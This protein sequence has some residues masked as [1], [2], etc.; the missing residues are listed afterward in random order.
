MGNFEFGDI[1]AKASKNY[2]IHE[3]NAQK[4][5][6]KINNY[7]AKDVLD[8]MKK[9]LRYEVV[10]TAHKKYWD[11]VQP[12]LQSSQTINILIN[13]LKG[14]TPIAQFYIDATGSSACAFRQLAAWMLV[15]K[16]LLKSKIDK[17]ELKALFLDMLNNAQIKTPLKKNIIYE[18]GILCNT[19][20]KDAI[21]ALENITDITFS[22]YTEDA[23]DNIKNTA[24]YQEKETYHHAILTLYM[25]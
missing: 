9:I 8:L 16:Y 15:E 23:L 21:A 20:D 1:R 5:R 6:K 24:K 18:L 2:E 13:I 19:A 25:F 11:E 4:I 10:R 14:R 12:I 17:N 22:E 7:T 3:L